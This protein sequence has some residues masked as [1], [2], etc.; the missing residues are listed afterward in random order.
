MTVSAMEDSGLDKAWAEMRSLADWRRA[1]GHWDA[2][3]AAQ[4][5]HWF[6]DEV[7]QGLLAALTAN[8]ETREAMRT[9]GDAVARGEMTPDSAAAK[10]LQSLAARH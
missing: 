3:R 2:R 4:A 6:E 8:P 9:T 10:V 5:R 1:Q 7:R